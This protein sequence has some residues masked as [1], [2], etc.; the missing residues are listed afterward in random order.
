MRAPF[1]F[2]AGLSAF[3]F[4]A[5]VVYAVLERTVDAPKISIVEGHRSMSKPIQIKELPALGDPLWLYI[6]V[7]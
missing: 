7:W 1:L 4:S 2:S 5:C 3:S 6:A